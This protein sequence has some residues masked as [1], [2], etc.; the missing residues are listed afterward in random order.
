MIEKTVYK[1]QGDGRDSWIIYYSDRVPEIVF[2][3]PSIQKGLDI[4]N[5]DLTTLTEEQKQQLKE[6]LK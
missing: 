1:K 3:D 4:S 2:E 6:L 5:V